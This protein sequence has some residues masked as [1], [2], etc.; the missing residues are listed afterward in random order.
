M[1]VDRGVATC[2]GMSAAPERGGDRTDVDQALA[3]QRHPPGTVVVLLDEGGDVGVCHGCQVGDDRLDVVV[4]QARIGAIV[5][6]EHAHQQARATGD[7]RVEVGSRHHSGGHLHERQAA[8]GEQPPTNVCVIDAEVVQASGEQV[9]L[10][11]GG[12]K[13]ET[14]GVAGDGGV[15]AVAAGIDA[16]HPSRSSSLATNSPVEEAAGSTMLNGA[17]PGFDAWWSR[18]AKAA[19]DSATSSRPPSRS[20]AARSSAST[21]S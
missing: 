1:L 18:T 13:A 17:K 19:A 15:G 4:V 6:T 12:G 5:G 20:A 7:S 3:A 8:I 21:R 16:C 2:P 10:R 14:A 9:G 11:A